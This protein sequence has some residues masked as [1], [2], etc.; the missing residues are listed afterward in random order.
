M[1]SLLLSSRK[2][3]ARHAAHYIENAAE[4]LENPDTAKKRRS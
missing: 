4:S 2:F 1:K 3:A